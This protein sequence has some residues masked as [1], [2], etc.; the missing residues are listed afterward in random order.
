MS[1][2]KDVLFGIAVT[3]SVVTILTMG[4]MIF[5]LFL[6]FLDTYHDQ[7]KKGKAFVWLCWIAIVVVAW[8][9]YA[10]VWHAF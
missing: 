4:S 8:V 10:V 5:G 1:V 2:I 3:F 9:A 7:S 6:K